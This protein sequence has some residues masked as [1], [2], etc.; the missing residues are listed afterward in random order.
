[1][2]NRTATFCYTFPMKYL[3]LTAIT[4]IMSC[5]SPIAT[6]PPIEV[7]SALTFS[8]ANFEPVPTILVTTIEYARDHFGGLE[9]VVYNLPVGMGSETYDIVTSRVEGAKPLQENGQ[10]A[11]HITELRVRGFKAEA[12]I[13]FPGGGG[14]ETATLYLSKTL[15]GPWKVTRERVWLI[16]DVVVPSPN[17][18]GTEQTVIVDTE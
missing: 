1:M 8:N 12:N 6:Y 7:E 10:Q 13:T 3:L 4:L 2:R 5:C 18:V 17:Y 11:Y 14:Y 16:P 15:S 9:T